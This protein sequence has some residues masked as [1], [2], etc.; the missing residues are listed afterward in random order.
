ML[1][2]HTNYTSLITQNNLNK[3]SGAMDN[4]MQRIS[5]GLRINSASDDA[6]GLQIATRLQSQVNGLGVAQR[7]AQ[8][9][10]SMMQTAEGA[11]DE[12]TNISHRMK[13]LATQAANGTNSADEHDAM[14]AEWDQ[15]AAELDS[16]IENTQFGS[17]N[18]LFAAGGQ[19]D[20]A[21]T[22]QIGSSTSETLTVDI[23][24]GLGDIRDAIG[25]LASADLSA[26]GDEDPAGDGSQ[27][28]IP[29]GA[30]LAMDAVDALL[31]GNADPA[32]DGSQPA[33]VGIG[34]VRSELGA[35]IN[36]LDHTITNLGNMA[37]NT[38]MAKGRIMDTDYAVESSNMM[39]NQMLTQMSMSMLSQANGM[40]GMVMSL[41]G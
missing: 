39:K 20:G 30:A 28:A 26:A 35:N 38:E 2:I 27:P 14:Q 17:G 31:N 16:V 1:S 29:S 3:T 36:R 6:A 4:A 13:D 25:A 32:G 24:D 10:T 9:A 40:S 11:F 5:T 19:F 22:F 23:S 33:T 21:V 8:D 18:N 7:N 15:L 41:V 12:M 37:E 34:S